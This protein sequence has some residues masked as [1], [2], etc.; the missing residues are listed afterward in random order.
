MT[1]LAAFYT[2]SYWEA[3]HNQHQ[4]SNS[5]SSVVIVLRIRLEKGAMQ[6]LK[7]KKGERNVQTV[8]WI[9]TWYCVHLESNQ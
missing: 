4:K 7:S 5:F 3:E 1:A 9:A 6:L 2:L 8:Y